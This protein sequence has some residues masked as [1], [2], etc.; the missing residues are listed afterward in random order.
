MWHY[1]AKYS[2]IDQVKFVEDNLY[3]IWVCLD[4]P[5]HFNF[6]RGFLPQILLGRFLNTLSQLNL[7]LE[8]DVNIVNKKCLR[9]MLM[10]NKQRLSNTLELNS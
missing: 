9:M 2:R 3:K 5:Y 7:G 1:Y 10:R 4:R 6:F 8:I